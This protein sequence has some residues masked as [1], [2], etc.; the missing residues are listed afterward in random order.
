MLAPD[1]RRFDSI[2]EVRGWYCVEYA[3]PMP[4]FRFAIIQL[5]ILESRQA[6]EVAETMEREAREWL[7]RYPIPSMATAFSGDGCVIS[8]AGVRESDHLMAWPSPSDGKPIRRWEIV[9]DA[10]LPDIALN[11]RYVE[12]LFA[13][14]P[15]KTGRQINEEASKYLF[16][17]R[18][19][20][21]LVFV[22]AVAVPLGVAV[23]EWWS[24]LLGLVVLAYSFYKAIW[25]ALRL[26]GRLPKS[27]RERER[28]AEDLKM[29][30]H[31]YHCQRNPEAFERLKVENF[32]RWEI[33]QTSLEVDALRAKRTSSRVD[34]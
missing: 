4:N 16:R 15:F 11:R 32:R 17:R 10:V 25:T 28:E 13:T 18:V 7:S 34:D 6:S 3:P 5:T 9:E 22:W 8:M 1:E 33:E 24:D 20:W 19:G 21:W 27:R 14:V 30:H 31:H 23:L 12:E 29:R 2:K 26:G